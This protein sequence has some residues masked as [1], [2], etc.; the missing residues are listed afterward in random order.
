MTIGTIPELIGAISI[1]IVAVFVVQILI[2]L[3]R[4]IDKYNDEVNKKV[5]L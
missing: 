5:N 4:L 2:K 1:L 3:G